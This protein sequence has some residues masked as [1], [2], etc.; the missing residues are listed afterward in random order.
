MFDLNISR[1]VSVNLAMFVCL[2]AHKNKQNAERI[3]MT[4]S[5]SFIEVCRHMQLLLKLD[6]NNG[7]FYTR[8]DVHFANECLIS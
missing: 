1:N 7:C 2:S 5:G 6:K 4:L 8:T 3:F